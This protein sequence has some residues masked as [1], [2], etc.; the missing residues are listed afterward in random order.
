[1]KTSKV[2][3]GITL[4]G[5]VCSIV[6]F[7]YDIIP[8]I[9]WVEM[10]TAGVEDVR[11]EPKDSKR[12]VPPQN[13]EGK[14]AKLSVSEVR[15]SLKSMSYDD[16]EQ[17]IEDNINSM[18]DNLSLEELNSILAL[19]A[20]SDSKVKVTK[21]FAPR[22]KRNFSKSELEKFANLFSFSDDRKEALNLLFGRK[23]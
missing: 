7:C 3:I 22:V 13:R 8:E 9:N 16:Q 11:V 1:M 15:I 20:F 17:F 14:V 2:I 21:V 4:L 19:F 23:R 12:T 10:L 18:P 5:S 6:N